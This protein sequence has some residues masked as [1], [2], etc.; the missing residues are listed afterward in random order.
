MEAKARLAAM[1]PRLPT[2]DDTDR[3]RNVV[4][5]AALSDALAKRV[6]DAVAWSRILT[7]FPLAVSSV[8]IT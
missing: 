1:A 2:R 7:R 5:A 4:E 6:E 8:R 3:D